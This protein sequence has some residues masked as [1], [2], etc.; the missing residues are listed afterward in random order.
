MISISSLRH[1]AAEKRSS[2]VLRRWRRI[3]FHLP[4]VLALL[5]LPACEPMVAQRGKLPEQE[6]VAQIRPGVTTKENVTKAL[7]SPSSVATFDP[8]TWYYISKKTEQYAW[9]DPEILDQQ[10]LIIAF[11]TSGVVKDV[12]RR[13]LKDAQTVD[14]VARATPA[15]GRELSFFEQLVGNLGRFNPTGGNRRDNSHTGPGG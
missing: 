9:L 14:P 4:P 1:P 10:V 13:G 5:L 7:G 11:D 12:R 15:P 3:G 6:Q 2:A 8:N